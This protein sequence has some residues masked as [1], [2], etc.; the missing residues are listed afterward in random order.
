MSNETESR[1]AFE[2][3]HKKPLAFVF[4]PK[5]NEYQHRRNISN[6]DHVNEYN[7]TWAGWQSRDAEVGGLKLRIDQLDSLVQS[8]KGKFYEQKEENE[9]R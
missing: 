3:T 2:H 6:S 4:N 5:T 1:K 9:R 7:A 8:Y